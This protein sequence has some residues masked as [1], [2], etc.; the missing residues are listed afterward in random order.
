MEIGI[1]PGREKVVGSESGDCPM[2]R[3]KKGCCEKEV[4]EEM[5]VWKAK[6]R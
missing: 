3:E 2:R 1:L 4:E 6:R 5:H